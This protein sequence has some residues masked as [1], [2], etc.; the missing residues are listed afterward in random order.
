MKVTAESGLNMRE[1]PNTSALI[2]VSIPY[3]HLLLVC[4]STSGKLEI[5]QT[6]GYWRQ[7]SYD[8]KMGYV[9]DAYLELIDPQTQNE[10][11][12]KPIAPEIPGSLAEPETELV[13]PSQTEQTK[14]QQTS[15]PAEEIEQK[16][17]ESAIKVEEMEEV[18]KRDYDLVL[19]AYNYC[20]PV[21]EIDPGILWYG[22]YPANRETGETDMSVKPV[23]LE[24]VLSKSRSTKTLEFDIRTD[25][26][27]RSLF[28]IGSTRPLD[29]ESIDLTDR[30]ELLRY[31][32][33][34]VFPGQQINLDL[35]GKKLS[36]SATGAISSIGD[37]PDVENYKLIVEAERNVDLMTLVPS[38]QCG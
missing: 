10:P 22:F 19:E 27:E 7:A 2:V 36:L 17:E 38:G 33:Q 4:T 23:E 16:K 6:T 37:C 32:N 24:I 8:G 12:Q 5:A 30:S 14:E 20:G 15:E 1:Q 9:Y 26:P 18:P 34:K 31:S 3:D 13:P 21:E 35:N 28:M 25:Q 11:E 29:I